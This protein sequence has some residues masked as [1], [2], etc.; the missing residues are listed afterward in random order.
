MDVGKDL[1]EDTF[2][3]AGQSALR[4]LTCQVAQDPDAGVG[5]VLVFFE[6]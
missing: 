4:V 5:A 6:D 1:F 2:G 3:V